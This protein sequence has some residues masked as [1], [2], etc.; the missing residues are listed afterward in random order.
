MKT[1]EVKLKYALFLRGK[2]FLDE[3]YSVCVLLFL[4]HFEYKLLLIVFGIIFLLS[5]FIQTSKI[6]KIEKSIL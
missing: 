6:I 4:Y 3:V 5:M 2:L 1:E